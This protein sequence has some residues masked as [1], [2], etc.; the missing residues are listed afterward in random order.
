M[1]IDAATQA[2]AVGWLPVGAGRF[3]YTAA[4][5]TNGYCLRGAAP[6]TETLTSPPTSCG[7]TSPPATQ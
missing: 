4:A 6:A 7:R 3:A 2:K 5:G 1:R